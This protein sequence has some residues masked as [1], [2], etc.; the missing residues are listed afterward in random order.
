M[1]FKVSFSPA[2]RHEVPLAYVAVC[3]LIRIVLFLSSGLF[4][5]D[6]SLVAAEKEIDDFPRDRFVRA[7]TIRGESSRQGALNE[8][9]Q[10]FLS[11]PAAAEVLIHAL[12]QTDLVENLHA[13]TLRIMRILAELNDPRIT[14]AFV[15]RL[16][17]P[18]V[19][20]VMLTVD[21]LAQRRDEKA[22]GAIAQLYERD[23][24]AS[25]FGFRKC[26]LH[27]TM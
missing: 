21:L 24:F 25:S 20:T 11:E 13:S 10:K 1:R 22:L 17:S 7:L 18:N 6:A 5:G 27:A 23:E 19:R 2:D 4:H 9:E 26:M 3:L 12:E 8:I 14:D 15:S 16:A